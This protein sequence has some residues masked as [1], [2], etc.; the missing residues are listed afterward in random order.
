M[1]WSWRSCTAKYGIKVFGSNHMSRV[2]TRYKAKSLAGKRTVGSSKFIH[3]IKDVH[4]SRLPTVSKLVG[5]TFLKAL[6]ESTETIA[7]L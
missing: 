5:G 2:N 1:F 3:F 6:A 7:L 4:I